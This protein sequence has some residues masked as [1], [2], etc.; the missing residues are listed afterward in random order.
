MYVVVE[1]EGVV[2]YSLYCCRG[3]G[4]GKQ[5]GGG[6]TVLPLLSSLSLHLLYVVRT[7]GAPCFQRHC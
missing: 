7:V 1:G 3:G 2:S 4:G 6:K 5:E